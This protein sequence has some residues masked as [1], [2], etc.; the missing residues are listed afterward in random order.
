MR[1]RRVVPPV[2]LA[3]VGVAMVVACRREE[4]RFR[5]AP[6]AAT[7]SYAV[8]LNDQV[9]PGGG[10]RDPEIVAPYD[11]NA[12]A[13]SEGQQLFGQMN[14]AGCHSAGGG[15]GMGP[16]L[17]DSLWVY[18]S[19]PE[20]IFEPIVEGRPNGMPAY[21]E[22]LSND[23]IWRIVSYVRTLAALTSPNVRSARSEGMHN[24]AVPDPQKD[25][26]TPIAERIPPEQLAP[27]SPPD[28]RES[29][30]KQDS[31]WR[32]TVTNRS[33]TTRLRAKP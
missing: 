21:R 6:P 20:N 31:A 28:V 12:Y 23:Q 4:R 5:E 30:A 10:I 2:A 27:N 26:M 32:D 14:C 9:Q 8:T 22:R 18:G 25:R 29:R 7:A 3:L 24:F 17:I 1:Q 33:D 13:V 19:E 11:N 15:G 16:P